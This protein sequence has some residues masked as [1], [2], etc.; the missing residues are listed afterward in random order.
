M[1]RDNSNSTFTYATNTLRIF[2]FKTF[3][4]YWMLYA[5][6]WVIPR[7]LKFIRRRFGTLCM[8]HLHRQVG[9]C[10]MNSA[11][12]NCLQPSSLYTNLPAY[13]D[14]T[15]RVPK[16]RQ[17]NFRR[18]GITQKKSYNCSYTLSKVTWSIVTC[19]NNYNLWEDGRIRGSTWDI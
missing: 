8:F 4:V 13:E 1:H 15:D 14:G 18:R 10:R 2:W 17:I 11:E 9:A 16:R 6:F 3:T 12:G 7:R 19:S 5:F